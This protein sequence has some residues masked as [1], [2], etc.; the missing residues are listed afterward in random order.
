MDV[1]DRTERMASVV[2]RLETD[3]HLLCLT[4]VEDRLQ[5]EVTTS[6]ELLRNAG[7]KVWMLTGDKLET[8]ICIA[9]SSG[10][11]SKSDN[12]HVFGQV[13][14]RTEAHNELNALRK[15]V[16]LSRNSQLIFKF[17]KNDVALVMSGAALNV[18]LQYYEL[19]VAELVCAC[20]AVVCC[21]CSPEQKAQIVNLLKRYR[22]PLR[23]AAI[24][25][26]G[27][28]VSMIQGKVLKI[29]PL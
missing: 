1:R 27:N 4:G 3:L 24:G 21:R 11:F 19:E 13:Q 16:K 10:L 29:G 6:L 14:D 22:K 5:D 20:T 2:R 9:K 12:I 26:G 17:R 23:V 25:D 18:C 15:Q 28:D 8:A 7:I